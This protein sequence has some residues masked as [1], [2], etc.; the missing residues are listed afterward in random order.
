MNRD[1]ALFLC[2]CVFL[3]GVECEMSCESSTISWFT[4]LLYCG[5]MW[6]CLFWRNHIMFWDGAS[7]DYDCFWGITWHSWRAFHVRGPWLAI[8]H[9]RFWSAFMWDGNLE[10]GHM[11]WSLK[12]SCEKFE[13]KG[14]TWME[15]SKFYVNVLKCGTSH[16]WGFEMVMWNGESD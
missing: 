13:I 15:V 4:W 10:R 7:C 1:S 14:F 6:F 11:I 9:D 5:G 12:T 8:S 2:F 3:W 16:A